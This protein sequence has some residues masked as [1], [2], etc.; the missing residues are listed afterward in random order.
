VLGR[1]P[2]SLRFAYGEFGKPSLQSEPSVLQDEPSVRFNLSHS[3]ELGLLAVA[4]HA[5]LGVDIESNHARERG[6]QIARRFFAALEV[7]ALMAL[8]VGERDAGFL[9]CWTRKEAYVKA[10]GGGLQTP[11]DGFAVTLGSDEPARLRWCSDPGELQR[12]TLVD[13]SDVHDDVTAAACV[14]A[15]AARVRVHEPDYVSRDVRHRR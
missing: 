3:G 14:E 4:E 13:L 9:R 15:A 7:E 2:A 10:L 1:D 8:P 11:L 5:E 12:W 6:E